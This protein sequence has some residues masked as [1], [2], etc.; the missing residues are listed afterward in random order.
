MCTMATTVQ[1]LLTQDTMKGFSLIAGDTSFNTAISGINIMDNPDTVPWLSKGALILSTG[2]FFTD[3]T[4]TENLIQN[5]VEKGCSGLGIKMNRYLTELPKSMLRQA[6]ELHFPIIDIPFSSSMDQ[7][8]NLVYR[9]LYEDEMDETQRLSVL[10]RDISECVLKKQ[11]L[12][13]LLPLIGNATNSS[14]FLTNDSFEIIEYTLHNGF[15]YAFPFPFCKDSYTLF[16]KADISYLKENLSED[17]HL[18]VITHSVAAFDT[19][20]DFQIFPLA[21]R[22]TL[23]GFLILLN[24]KDTP[25]DSYDFIMNIRSVL[26]MALMNH[27]ILTEAERSSRDIFFYN[28]LSGKVKSEQ[29]IEPLCLQ[30]HFDFKKNRLCMVLRIPEYEDMTIAKRRAFERK[31]FSLFDDTLEVPADS[32][33][34][35]VF[36]THFVLFFYLNGKVTQKEA[37]A[38]GMQISEKLVH[39]LHKKNIIVSIGIS[40]CAAGASTIYNCYTQ[41][42]QSLEIGCLLHPKENTFSYFKDQ[43]Y[44][45]LVKH[46]TS[47]E[48]QELY[49]EHLGILEQYDKENEAELMLTL[50]TYLKCFGNITQTA[51]ELFIHRNTMFYRLDQIKSLLHIDFEN[52]NDIY[53]I[54]T[55]FYIK[56]LLKKY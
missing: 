41:A 36:Q 38:Y 21:N 47:S 11:K 51:K 32:M 19:S 2:Y 1:W 10:Y 12:S 13:K 28:L 30:N 18:P 43:I 9:K 26:C 17:M 46:Y 40:K 37:S 50:S 25:A 20:L 29:E 48:L 34:R 31:V 23:L 3:E 54:R 16:S 39:V 24:E 56:K 35:T 42:L 15:P 53:Q 5:L 8:A 6:E 44:H 55:G 7:I 22:N 49:N 45:L 4:L 14:V 52:E 27:T 33:I